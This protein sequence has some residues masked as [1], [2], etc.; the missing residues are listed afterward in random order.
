M[1][2]GGGR[3][4]ALGKVREKYPN[5]MTSFST[6]VHYADLSHESTLTMAAVSFS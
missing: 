1:E 4:R 5:Y 6:R 3:E 2:G